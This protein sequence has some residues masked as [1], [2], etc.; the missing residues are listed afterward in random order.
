M[1]SAYEGVVAA[2]SGE[3]RILRIHRSSGHG[4][5]DLNVEPLSMIRIASSSTALELG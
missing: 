4:S 3:V 2:S 1:L 5:M